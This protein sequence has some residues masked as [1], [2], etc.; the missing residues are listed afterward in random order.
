LFRSSAFITLIALFSNAL[1]FLIQLILARRYGIGLDVDVYLYTLS[2]PVF[3]SGIVSSVLSYQLIPRLIALE[4]DLIYY[5]RFILTFFVGL[6][7]FAV[8]TTI[9]GYIFSFLNHRFITINNPLNS[10]PKFEILT[11]L[12]WLICFFQIFQGGIGSVLNSQR[13]HVT[14]AIINLLPYIGMLIIFEFFNIYYGIVALTLGLLIGTI[15]GALYGVFFIR[16]NFVSLTRSNLIWK[17]LFQVISG[18]PYAIMALSCFSA[19]LLV[20]AYWA[21]YYGSGTLSTLGYAQRIVI[22]FGN[23]AVAG[24]SA[25]LVPRFAELIRDRDVSG[26]RLMVKRSIL[27]IGTIA[28]SVALIMALFSESIVDLLF[29]SGSFGDSDVTEVSKT[30]LFMLPGMV[31][32]LVSVILYR[33]M[34]C[35]DKSEKIA[36]FLGAAWTIAYFGI[37]SITYKFGSAGFAAGYSLVWIFQLCILVVVLLKLTS[38]SYKTIKSSTSIS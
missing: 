22:A 38:N 33:A 6:L 3:I 15:I 11:K 20:D 12:G 14:A 10:H 21:P 5:R 18:V 1:G 35:I 28:T 8:F 13:Q 34:F 16:M 7:V 26:F 17:D 27:V 23:L 2:F 9:S 4:T 19:Y 25:V 24:P 31:A 37:S 36:G 29:H 30:L 32:M